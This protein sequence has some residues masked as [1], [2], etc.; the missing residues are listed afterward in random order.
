M[1][2]KDVTPEMLSQIKFLFDQLKSMG[3]GFDKQIT[4]EMAGEV[5]EFAKGRM[6]QREIDLKEKFELLNR[7]AMIMGQLRRELDALKGLVEEEMQ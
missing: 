3:T 1:I 6:Y 2:E 4:K 7:Y 5:L